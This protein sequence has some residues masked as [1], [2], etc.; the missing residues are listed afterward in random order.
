MGKVFEIKI[1]ADKREFLEQYIEDNIRSI[2]HQAVTRSMPRILRAQE[3]IIKDA[4]QQYYSVPKKFYKRTGS[5]FTVY[6]MDDYGFDFDPSHMKG[7]HRVGNKYIYEMMFEQGYHGGAVGDTGRLDSIG[8]AKP[9]SMAYRKPVRIFGDSPYKAFSLWSTTPP[10]Q[11]KPSPEE[12]IDQG[13]A[14]YEPKA[15]KIVSDEF[16]KMISRI[17][18]RG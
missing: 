16:E 8:V 11:S 17:I 4:I 14:D 12:L 6:K 1:K 9:W 5:L 7:E 18:R 3:R 15:I 10:R 2:V 13:L